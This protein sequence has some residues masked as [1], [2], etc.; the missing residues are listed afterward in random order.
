[1]DKEYQKNVYICLSDYSKAFDC[2]D[3]QALLN[4]LQK[5]GIPERMISL[6]HGLVRRARS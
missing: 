5:M 4:C 6:L 2:V 1:M 3:N